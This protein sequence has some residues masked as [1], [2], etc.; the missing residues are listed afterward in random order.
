MLTIIFMSIVAIFDI[1]DSDPDCWI[2]PK[3]RAA[4]FSQEAGGCSTYSAS[5]GGLYIP[6]Q[7]CLHPKECRDGDWDWNS[8]QSKLSCCL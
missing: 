5:Y 3:S 2:N 8:C 6:W 4:S 1:F 7:A